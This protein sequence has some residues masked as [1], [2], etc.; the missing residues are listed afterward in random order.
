MH[1]TRNKHTPLS[2]SAKRAYGFLKSVVEQ[3]DDGI[4]ATTARS[5]LQSADGVTDCLAELLE[6]GYLYEVGDTIYVT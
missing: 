1:P 4:P 2:P 6:K 5:R 3:H